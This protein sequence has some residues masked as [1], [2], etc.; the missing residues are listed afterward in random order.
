MLPV[1]SADKWKV[2][3]LSTGGVVFYSIFIMLRFFVDPFLRDASQ[4]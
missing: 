3:V 1:I 4:V 2:K